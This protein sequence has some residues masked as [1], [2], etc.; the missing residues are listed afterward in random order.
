MLSAAGVGAALLLGAGYWTS[1]RAPPPPEPMAAAAAVPDGP[2]LMVV[3]FEDLGGTS[4]AELYATGLTEE[5]LT[6]LAPF[7]ELT[8]LGRETSRSLPTRTDVVRLRELGARYAL[9]GGVRATDDRLRVTARLLDTTNAAVLWSRAYD[10]DLHV[11]DL[12]AVQEDIARQVATAVAQPYGIVFRADAR[13]TSRQAPDDLEAHACTLRF[14]TYRTEL[15]PGLHAAIRDCLRR[16]VARYPDYA[17][18]WAML[19][20]LYL[21]EDRFGYNPEPGP[22][23]PS[24]RALE[25]ARRAVALDPESGRA[26]QA[27]ML[28]LC[29]RQEVAEGL[30][31]G[32]LAL[33]LN[34]ND[35]ELLGEF[36]TRVALSG[37]WGRGSAL[38]EQALARNPGHFGYYHGV[39]ALVAYMR[40]DNDRALAEIRQANLQRFPIYHGIAAVIYAELGKRAEATQA[41]AR[42]VQMSP[43]FLPNLDAELAK[44]NIGSKD[45]ARLAEGLRKAGLPVPESSTVLN[46]APTSPGG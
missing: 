37:E 44:Y 29:F 14:Y 28:A 3:P 13:W 36:G 33:A 12:F 40:R 7:K 32:E 21:D 1:V 17:T 27:L 45:R 41:G 38:I 18:A 19:S 6:Q 9:E 26:L 10:E 35:T 43:R 34:P 2:T 22:P 4:L 15:S 8:V 24:D 42:S 30:R 23:T 39:L 31:V 20:I 5:I 11:R 16:A 46:T 25:A